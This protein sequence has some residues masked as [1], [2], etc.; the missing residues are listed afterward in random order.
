MSRLTTSQS[1]IP[2]RLPL[3]SGGAAPMPL[4]EWLTGIPV[5]QRVVNRIGV[6]EFR[7]RLFHMTPALLPFILTL[8]PHPHVWGPILNS[9]ILLTAFAGIMVAIIYASLLTRKNELSWM[10]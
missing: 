1:M 9:L 3:T 2:T 5:V 7:R 6:T 8:V 10:S 4:P